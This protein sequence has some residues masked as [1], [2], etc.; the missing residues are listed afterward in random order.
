M[1]KQKLNLF[2]AIALPVLAAGLLLGLPGRAAAATIKYNLN[3]VA[4][5][6]YTA[7]NA[8][9]V[10]NV[11]PDFDNMTFTGWNTQPD[12]SGTSYKTGDSIGGDATLYA[13]WQDGTRLKD[14]AKPS[15]G[16][17][18]SETKDSDNPVTPIETAKPADKPDGSEGTP[19]NGTAGGGS[20]ASSNQ[21][22]GSLSNFNSNANSSSGTS[23]LLPSAGLAGRL[24]AP[25]NWL[26]AGLMGAIAV[27][28]LTGKSTQRARQ[29]SFLKQLFSS[30]R[31]TAVLTTSLILALVGGLRI[32]MAP[33]RAATEETYTDAKGNPYNGYVTVVKADKSLATT[34]WHGGQ[35]MTGESKRNNNTN[36]FD[37]KND[38][39]M[40]RNKDLSYKLPNENEAY[41]Y[42]YDADGNKV[43][44]N[45]QKDGFWSHYNSQTG[46]QEPRLVS[47]Q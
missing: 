20:S 36:Y 43:Y 12:G 33:S 26:I 37:P 9:A 24:A 5:T 23:S 42:R 21:N 11:V 32:F 25:G 4:P 16:G 31:R 8:T 28:L 27:L 10:A 38:G 46:K 14:L 30:R 6:V 22:A 13:Q 47:S 15:T 29:N 35:Q 7:E 45:S 34:W 2:K 18:T 41:W 1:V 44:G 17:N 40:V 39:L 3:G 19:S